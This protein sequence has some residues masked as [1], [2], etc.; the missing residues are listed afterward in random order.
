[1]TS[2]FSE[3]TAEYS[4]L[5]TVITYFRYRFGAAAPMYFWASREGN[6]AAHE[7]HAGRQMRV[8]V[9]FARRPKGWK[10]EMLFGKINADLFEFAEKATQIG[11]PCFAGFPAVKSV[12][13]LGE[14]FRTYWFPLIGRE[15]GDL[16]F[17]VDLSR[18]TLAPT[19][20]G[21]DPLWTVELDDLG[22]A[23][24]NA[25][26]LPWSAVTA[27]IRSMRRAP[28]RTSYGQFFGGGNVYSPT[29]ILVPD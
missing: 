22:D 11:L 13:E 14:E 16:N 2:F 15:Q 12:L 8:L 6:A 7:V 25:K 23:V 27:A 3:R 19:T 20:M 26:S 29:Y 5:P 10:G 1:M 24:Q 4:I 21:G 18:P 17:Q 28:R 9:L